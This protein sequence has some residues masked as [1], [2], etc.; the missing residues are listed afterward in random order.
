MTA[1]MD[2]KA[3]VQDLAS[4]IQKS[5]A[6]EAQSVKELLELLVEDAKD[7]LLEA[8]PS[9]FLKLQGEAAALRRLQTMLTRAVPR[10]RQGV[11]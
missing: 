8:Q 3:R 9:E 2:R 7:A 1:K 6:F 10:L 4:D 11:E 5:S